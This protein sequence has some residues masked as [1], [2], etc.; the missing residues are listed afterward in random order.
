MILP[1]YE[2]SNKKLLGLD[3]GPVLFFRL[4]FVLRYHGGIIGLFDVKCNRVY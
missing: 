3:F 2:S 1:I 4:F